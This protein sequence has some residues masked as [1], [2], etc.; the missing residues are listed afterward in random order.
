MT[1]LFAGIV[2]LVLAVLIV[3]QVGLADVAVG[4]TPVGAQPGDQDPKICV[5][6]RDVTIGWDA[7]PVGINALDYRTG[8]YAFTGEMIE[9]TI[10]IRDPNGALD[11]GF[12][13]IRVAGA[14]EVLCNEIHHPCRRGDEQGSEICECNG[15]GELHFGEEGTDRAYVCHLTVEPS[16]YG[17]EE[18]KI[19]AYNSAFEPTDSTHV[20][21]WFFNPSLSMSVST[22][23]GQAIHFEEMPY[24]ADEPHERTVHSENRLVVKNTAEGGVNMWMYL[25]GTD[26]YDPS[27]A[28]KCPVTNRLDLS[29]MAYR[30]WSGTQW[31]SWQGWVQMEKYD[32]NAACDLIDD[33]SYIREPRD[34]DGN[35]FLDANT[36]MRCYG[37]LPVPYDYN[38]PEEDWLSHLLT[39]QGKLEVEFKLEYPI[40]CVGTFTQGS[41]MVFGKA[42]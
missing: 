33:G 29:N 22:S 9:F 15:F 26:L 18:V 19:T 7:D 2:S 28:S 23:D 6:H 13:K 21:T 34:E 27:G 5:Y 10:V 14:S 41:L 39:N 32:Q 11:I 12:P 17:E 16:W 36:N 25:A 35:Q 4:E 1:K 8:L 37:G 30:A 3:G 31:T 24:G 38:V 42:V 40:P 20:E